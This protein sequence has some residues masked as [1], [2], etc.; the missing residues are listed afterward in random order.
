MVE[1]IVT[2]SDLVDHTD[3]CQNQRK[4]YSHIPIDLEVGPETEEHCMSGNRGLTVLFFFCYNQYGIN[5]NTRE[6]GTHV[7]VLFRITSPAEVIGPTQKL[8]VAL[9][10]T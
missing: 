8:E 4:G 3:R 10:V 2:V 6:T 7:N 9:L 1:S 5:T